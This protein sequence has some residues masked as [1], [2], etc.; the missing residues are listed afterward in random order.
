M[1]ADRVS[2]SVPFVHVAD[3]QRS[4]DFYA[5]LGFEVGDTYHHGD[6]LDWAFL[7]AGS[8]RIMVAHAGEP[9]DPSQQAVLFYLYARDLAGLREHLVA[10][11]VAA[12][13]IFDG[14]PG[15]REEMRVSDPDGY[16]LMIA[17][18]EEDSVRL[19]RGG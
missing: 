14:T 1:P 9:V 13:P 5:L 2:D 18:I 3:V 10:N 8:A 16:C 15:P 12:S 7:Q 4:I 11:G 17:R 19:V 6:R